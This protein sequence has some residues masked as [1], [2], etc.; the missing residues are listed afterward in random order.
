MRRHRQAEW[1]TLRCLAVQE[2]AAEL[3]GL[4]LDNGL[5][6]APGSPLVSHGAPDGIGGAGPLLPVST[7]TETR[8]FAVAMAT[9]ANDT[10]GSD[11]S[12][13]HV[14]PLIYWT[15]YMVLVTVFSRPQLGAILGKMEKEAAERWDRKL[16]ER[17]QPGRGEWEV[18]DFG[19]AVIHVFT[20][21]Q[22]EYYDL[23]SF[24]GA[25][26]EVELP[27]V[28]EVSEDMAAWNNRL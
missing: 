21:E 5:E 28:Q 12:V 18:L 14:E 6:T 27:F 24:Y 16:S 11:I 9:I 26:E 19:D 7:D 3:Q 1:A 13:L 20:A 4:D 2:E 10:R 25:A 15:R 8:D 22:R 23:E 17:G